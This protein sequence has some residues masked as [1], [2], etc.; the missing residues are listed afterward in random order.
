MDKLKTANQTITSLHKQ[1]SEFK[2]NKEWYQAQIDQL[3]LDLSKTYEEYR[4]ERDARKILVS[5]LRALQAQNADSAAFQSGSVG[6]K[7][8]DPVALALQLDVCKEDLKRA[9]NELARVRADYGDVVPKR[10]FEEQ[11]KVLEAKGEKLE[12]LEADFEKLHAEHQ[13]LLE[14]HQQISKERNEFLE[15]SELLRREATPRPSWDELK[16]VWP[17]IGR[18]HV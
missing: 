15:Q 6:E 13:T 3:K 7:G 12:F 17:E 11:T 4:N 9:T 2:Q 14:L 5:E 18:A 10:E 1:I 16:N 8:H